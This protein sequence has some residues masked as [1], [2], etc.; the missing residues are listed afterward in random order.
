MRDMYKVHQILPHIWHIQECMDNPGFMTLVTGSRKA[1][2]FDTGYGSGDLASAVRGLTSLPLEVVLSH[3]HFDHV[4]GAWQFE[5]AWIHPEDRE[6]C[7]L[8]SGKE[9]RAA[10]WGVNTRRRDEKPDIPRGRDYEAYIGDGCC[11]L[12]ELSYGQVFDLGNVTAKVIPMPGHTA[13]S[14]GL[15]LEEDRIFL[16]GD[17]ANP[18]F[19]LF[20][21]Y[22][23]AWEEHK[24]NLRRVLSLPC[25]RFLI[26]HRPTVFPKLKMEDFLQAAGKADP[27]TDRIR[28][29]GGLYDEPVYRSQYGE[30]EDPE[31][32]YMLYHKSQVSTGKLYGWDGENAVVAGADTERGIRAAEEYLKRDVR[33][34]AWAG[35]TVPKELRRL[36]EEYG[37]RLRIFEEVNLNDRERCLK[38]A[39]ITRLLC[40]KKADFFVCAKED[41]TISD[42]FDDEEETGYETGN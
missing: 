34:F 8:S 11:S 29:M 22:S 23:G 35:R 3:G 21:G 28:L 4:C 40:G 14:I 39:K 38:A 5:R 26:G 16:A 17:G 12:Q 13:G 41:V 25:D 20:T 31:S 24:A 10:C 2:L 36:Q 30:D 15:L 32:C 19:F 1:L 27:S 18:T 42:F 9:T 33:V 6:L 7:L 37:D